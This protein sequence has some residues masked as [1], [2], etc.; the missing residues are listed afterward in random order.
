MARPR[1]P[2]SSASFRS[3]RARIPA[4]PNSVTSRRFGLTIP[5]PWRPARR[6][7]KLDTSS[8]A[9]SA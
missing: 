4:R 5:P 6:L 1:P 8:I 3:T 9:G 7:A 2:T